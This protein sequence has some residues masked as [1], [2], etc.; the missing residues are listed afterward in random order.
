VNLKETVVITNDDIIIVDEALLNEVQEAILE[1][2]RW[3]MFELRRVIMKGFPDIGVHF[4]ATFGRASMANEISLWRRS[5][6]MIVLKY[7]CIEMPLGVKES[8]VAFSSP[9]T[10]YSSQ[11]SNIIYHNVHSKQALA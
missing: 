9:I 3:D 4:H 7:I 5:S 10:K 6:E 11:L 1:R 2:H 8:T